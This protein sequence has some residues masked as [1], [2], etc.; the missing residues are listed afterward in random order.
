MKDASLIAVVTVDQV[1]SRRSPDRVPAALDSLAHLSDRMLL[2]FERTVGDELQA[3][4]LRP[5]AVVDAVGRLTRLGGWRIGIGLGTIELPLPES[6]REARG[7][8]YVAA[9]QAV[10]N[11]RRAPTQLALVAAPEIV[12]AERYRADDGRRAESALVL[13]RWLLQRRTEE[14][15]AVLEL[16][17][18]GL[19]GKDAAERLGITPSAVSQRLAHA[20]RAEGLLGAALANDLL[21]RAM[22]V[23]S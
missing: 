17:E 6:T 4:S 3:A 18:S 19:T 20:G 5:D 10:T 8:A 16:V 1:G 12:R 22:G 21:A 13:W 23:A 7:T 15:W 9:R 11:A 2:G 14:G